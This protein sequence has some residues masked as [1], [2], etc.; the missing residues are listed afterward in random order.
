MGILSFPVSQKR[1]ALRVR[2]SLTSSQAIQRCLRELETEAIAPR[3]S[4]VID[5][6]MTHSAKLAR[7]AVVPHGLRQSRTDR[8]HFF[9]SGLATWAWLLVCQQPTGARLNGK[10]SFEEPKV[11]WLVL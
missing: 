11:C 7:A 6:P 8:T 2:V 9:L 4:A 5:K 10:C 3:D 1:R